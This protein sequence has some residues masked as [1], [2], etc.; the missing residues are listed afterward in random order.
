MCR[1]P[2]CR[3]WYTSEVRNLSVVNSV[4][5]FLVSVVYSSVIIKH[6]D[7]TGINANSRPN[8][9]HLGCMFMQVV[10]GGPACL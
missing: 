10:Y 2:E 3:R 9:H 7:Y 5:E 1:N 4:A 8:M 6:Q